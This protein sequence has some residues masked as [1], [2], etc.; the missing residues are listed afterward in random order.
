MLLGA[1]AAQFGEPLK[2]ELSLSAERRGDPIK[3]G[4]T[5]DIPSSM[6]T[7]VPAY[8]ITELLEMP[9]FKAQRDQ[10]EAEKPSHLTRPG[11]EVIT[12]A[13]R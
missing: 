7:V 11:A 13:I 4:E 8:R 5:I 6:A 2:V 1:H 3:E 10:R 9:K 12:K